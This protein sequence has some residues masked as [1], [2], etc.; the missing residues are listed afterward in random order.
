MARYFKLGF[1][2]LALLFAVGA[3]GTGGDALWT[4]WTGCS[5]VPAGLTGPFAQA[6]REWCAHMLHHGIVNEVVALV[7]G[8]AALL[9]IRS[10]AT[11]WL[12]RR[13]PVEVT[14]EA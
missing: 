4:W 1:G 6:D 12:M 10:R 2:V 8:V 9:A 7:V 3:G 11:P 14:P 13:P 5:S